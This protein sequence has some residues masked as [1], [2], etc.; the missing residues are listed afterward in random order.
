MGNSPRWNSGTFTPSFSQPPVVLGDLNNHSG[1]QEPLIDEVRN[2][3]ASDFEIG[4]CEQDG[5]DDCDY[6]AGNTVRRL[7]LPETN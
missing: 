5:T 3:T 6:H 2:I 1:G 4:F 7:A